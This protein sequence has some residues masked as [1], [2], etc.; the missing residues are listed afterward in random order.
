MKLSRERAESAV[1]YLVDNFGID[2]SRLTAKG[3]GYT[4]RVAYNST[5]DGRAKN[6]RINAIIDCVVTK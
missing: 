1:R 5:P 6:R 4:R 3:Y 2:K